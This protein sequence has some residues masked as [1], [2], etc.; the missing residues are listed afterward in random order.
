MCTDLATSN[1]VLDLKR[2]SHLLHI[3]NDRSYSLPV[4]PE[5]LW[6]RHDC[7]NGGVHVHP[8]RGRSLASGGP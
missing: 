3:E 5:L 4:M 8:L 7:L 2:P 6:G 1:A